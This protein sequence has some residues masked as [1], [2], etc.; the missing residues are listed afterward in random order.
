MLIDP[1]RR[2][3]FVDSSSYVANHHKTH[4]E[5]AISGNSVLIY[6]GLHLHGFYT[7]AGTPTMA[8]ERSIYF[9]VHDSFPPPYLPPP[10]IVVSTLTTSDA[11]SAAPSSVDPKD[12]F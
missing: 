6:P 10:P 2:P 4:F 5:A 1:A 7:A 12:T 8:N 3:A 11:V 9:N